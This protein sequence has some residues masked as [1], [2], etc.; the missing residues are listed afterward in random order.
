MTD[1]ILPPLQTMLLL[2]DVFIVGNRT[3]MSLQVSGMYNV[4]DFVTEE[5]LYSGKN[6]EEAIRAFTTNEEGDR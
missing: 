1:Y 3:R 4:V 5:L 6:E 2:P